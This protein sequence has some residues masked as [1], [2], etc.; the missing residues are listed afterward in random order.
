MV[1]TSYSSEVTAPRVQALSRVTDPPWPILPFTF[2]AWPHCAHFRVRP[3]KS[4]SW[5]D[6]HLH[7]A[8]ETWFQSSHFTDNKKLFGV[9]ARLR[10]MD[11]EGGRPHPRPWAI[12]K[13]TGP[14]QWGR[15]AP[16]IQPGSTQERCP[17]K[18]DWLPSPWPWVSLTGGIKVHVSA[19]PLRTSREV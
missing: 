18:E 10:H 4:V 17:R 11:W 8:Q 6:C 2:S 5:V 19:W 3:L 12:A 1:T 9:K 7:E 14:G 15:R 16:R 13:V